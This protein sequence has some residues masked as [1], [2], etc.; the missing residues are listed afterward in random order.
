MRWFTAALA[1]LGSLLGGGLAGWLFVSLMEVRGGALPLRLGLILALGCAAAL[2]GAWGAVL[3]I[4]RSAKAGPVLAAPSMAMILLSLPDPALTAVAFR[5]SLVLGL[6]AMAALVAPPEPRPV[7]AMTLLGLLL[8]GAVLPSFLRGRFLEA[9]RQGSTGDV[10]TLLALGVGVEEEGPEGAIPLMLAIEAEDEEMVDLLLRRGASPYARD[11]AGRSAMMIS[12]S[13]G[14]S[15]LTE[16][17]VLAGVGFE[18]EAL[19]GAD[20]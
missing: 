8:V 15:R 17:L 18:A 9:V 14:T 2:T 12:I 20:P 13:R 11:R 4:R 3:A 19:V 1:L 6:A 16:R 10:E 7:W 5:L